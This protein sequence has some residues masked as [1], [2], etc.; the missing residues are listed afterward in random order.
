MATD[1]ITNRGRN[2]SLRQMSLTQ[3]QRLVFWIVILVEV[4][5]LVFI[6]TKL[7][8]VEYVEES[9]CM[10]M[11]FGPGEK[12]LEIMS[13]IKRIYSVDGRDQTSEPAAVLADDVE[14]MRHRV[15]SK[16]PFLMTF[17]RYCCSV[18]LVYICCC[19]KR[20]LKCLRRRA[21]ELAHLEELTRRLNLETDLLEL[22]RTCRI[23]R[24]VSQLTLHKF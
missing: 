8:G 14:L 19:L 5:L 4:L 3:R 1:V 2:F 20:R 6:G 13:L 11:G 23:S 18:F 22:V 24:L 12:I 7:I 15:K 17:R 16:R 21:K 10:D 9:D